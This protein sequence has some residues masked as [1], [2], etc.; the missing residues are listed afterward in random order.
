[1]ETKTSR[2]LM[3]LVGL[4]VLASSSLAL[5]IDDPI[6]HWE[7]DETSGDIA[8]DSAGSN[9]GVLM[10][11]TMIVSD[12]QRGLVA[13]F[14]G[15][16]DYIIV[17]DSP[18]LDGM[19]EITLAAWVNVRSWTSDPSYSSRI[20]SKLHYPQSCYEL[21]VSGSA[22]A[23]DYTANAGYYGQN[24]DMAIH[25]PDNSILL[26]EWYHIVSTNTGTQQKMYINGI[27]VGSENVNTG[28]INDNNIDLWL[29]QISDAYVSAWF[30]GLMDDVRI[31]DRALDAGEVQQLYQPSST[32]GLIAHWK[33]DD[34]VGTVAVD[35][36]GSND[37]TLMGDVAI[38]N[39]PQRGLVGSFD[40][41]GDYINVGD[42][43]SLDFGAA[44]SFTVSAWF[45]TSQDGVNTWMP[46]VEKRRWVPDGGYGYYK[47][48]YSVGI[49][50]NKLYFGFE[51]TTSRSTGISGNSIVNYGSWHN[52]TVVRDTAEDKLYLYLD[53]VLDAVPV[54]D[55]TVDS[56]A[57]SVEFQIGKRKA[58][59][60]GIDYYY[61]DGLMDDVRMYDRALDADE[62]AALYQEGEGEL[63]VTFHVDGVDGDDVAGDGLSRETAFATIQKGVDESL[64]GDTV[65][66]WPDVYDEEV[67]FAGKAITVKSADD[68]PAVVSSINGYAFS[69]Y[70][71]EGADSVLENFIIANGV[72][73]IY[74]DSSSP[75]IRNLTIANNQFGIVGWNGATPDIT[76][77]IFWNNYYGDL[78]ECEADNSWLPEDTGPIAYWKLDETTGSTASDEIGDNDGTLVNGPVWT[79]GEV[80]N[81][82][83][84]DGVDDYV[85]VADDAALDISGEQITVSAW[86]RADRIDERQ[87]I[88]AKNAYGANSWILEINPV[89]FG[90]GKI[91]FYIDLSGF[92]GNFGSNTAVAV[93]D[94]C[95]VVG[96]YDGSE[97]K[98]Y[99]NGQLDASQ[100]I[101]GAIPTND[102]PVRIGGGG[103]MSRYFDG[104][105]D[106]VAVYDRAL[107]AG[108]VERL[109]RGSL[110]GHG[111]DEPLFADANSGDYHLLSERGR[112]WPEHDVWVLDKVTSS[113]VDGGVV[114][115]DPGSEPMPNG[116]VINMGAYGGRAYASMSEWPVRGDINRDG[117]CN[118]LDFAILT[119]DWLWQADWME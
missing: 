15:S 96:V 64:D 57:T 104:S 80:G 55:A 53:G 48:G 33:L 116:A 92:D 115:D 51:D 98:I 75:T 60:P 62:I 13:S 71:G 102:Q 5:A 42:Q 6:A 23:Y 38:V 2:R 78:Y 108:E 103:N 29:G 22:S 41:S 16:G 10:G 84:F 68:E 63:P 32:D 20:I 36:V 114:A 70:S 31:Y 35:S 26:N 9:D 89:D 67:D 19:A 3:I 111:Y 93:G 95:H 85:G 14:D 28:P 43:D 97:K 54:T 50:Q 76:N 61:F 52:I 83:S 25:T 59:G 82:L 117:V 56:L 66:V 119:E 47:E 17:Q 37:G 8:Y 109:Y 69:F 74:V 18:E 112:Y 110:A 106:E 45:K 40:G 118:L 7:F 77:C 100:A 79:D 99:I 107:S 58:A 105:I 12:P 30:D 1:M 101:S 94:W 91:N 87:V 4:V 90:N 24:D 11:D 34:E 21:T 73:A 65:V 44:D 39:D 46:L 49:Y 27:E 88:V 81:A 86:I 72:Y 113:C